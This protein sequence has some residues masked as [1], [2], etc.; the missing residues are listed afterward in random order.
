MLSSTNWPWWIL[1]LHSI[2]LYRT[3]VIV[4]IQTMVDLY[5]S[6]NLVAGVFGEVRDR[7]GA[8]AK[9]VE[10]VGAL[11]DAPVVRGGVRRCTYLLCIGRGCVLRILLVMLIIIGAFSHH[12]LFSLRT[13]AASRGNVS[14]DRGK[15]YGNSHQ[16]HNTGKTLAMTL[17]LLQCRL[18]N[19]DKSSHVDSSTM[20][21]LDQPLTSKHWM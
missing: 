19:K 2:I 18:W 16:I 1:I 3:S 17:M 13:N 9:Q 15:I 14:I 5:T 6:S 8:L 4:A 7:P 20:R 21:R 12:F 10:T 11:V